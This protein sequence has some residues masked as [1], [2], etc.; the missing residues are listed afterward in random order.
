MGQ[1]LV[2][3]YIYLSC[4]NSS[5]IYVA[6]YDILMN[7]ELLSMRLSLPLP[8]SRLP[9]TWSQSNLWWINMF[10]QVFLLI[11]MKKAEFYCFC[12]MFFW[13]VFSFALSVPSLECIIWVLF[14]NREIFTLKR[15]QIPRECIKH[16]SSLKPELLH[17]YFIVTLF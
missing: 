11:N 8:L 10:I 7:S 12:Y 3:L 2:N 9:E 4:F 17:K 1:C 6:S 16:F 14:Y 15:Q 13:S 5:Q